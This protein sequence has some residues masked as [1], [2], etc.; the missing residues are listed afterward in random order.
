MKSEK[1]EF[2]D[3]SKLE[4]NEHQKQKRTSVARLLFEVWIYN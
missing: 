3:V 4:V 1:K 2:V